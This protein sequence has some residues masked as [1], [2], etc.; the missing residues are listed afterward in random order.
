MKKTTL[1]LIP[2]SAS[3]EAKNR[4]LK[5]MRASLAGVPLVDSSW[6]EYC[7]EKKALVEPTTDMYIRS[8][9]ARTPN[10]D[11]KFGVALLAA[12]CKENSELPMLGKNVHFMER[13]KDAKKDVQLLLREAGATHLPSWEAIIRLLKKK[14]HVTLL[15][16]K[17]TK[18][19]AAKQ[20]EIEKVTSGAPGDSNA[21]ISILTTNWLFDSISCGEV[22]PDAQYSADK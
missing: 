2:S 1:V 22:L 12:K 17:S 19:P 15:L 14:E 10:L 13:N 16:G 6:I 18:L 11:V 8:L 5:A 20:K 3:G 9:P 21:I 4:T 7:L